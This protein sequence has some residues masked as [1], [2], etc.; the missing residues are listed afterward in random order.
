M[1]G[2][3]L[4]PELLFVAEQAAAPAAHGREVNWGHRHQEGAEAEAVLAF[5]NEL[6]IYFFS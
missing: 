6:Y 1:K 5:V 3:F 4:L 2:R